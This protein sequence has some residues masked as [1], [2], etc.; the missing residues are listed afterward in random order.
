MM[1][2]SG[3]T[4]TKASLTDEITANFGADARFYTCSAV[5]LTAA[6]LVDFLDS[7]GKL[8]AAKG[9]FGTSPDLKCQH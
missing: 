3:R 8:I 7:K 2:A 9:G 4:Y 1:I 6:Q 5:D